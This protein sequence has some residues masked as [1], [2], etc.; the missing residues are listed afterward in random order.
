MADSAALTALILLDRDGV[1]N[2]DSPDYIRS[3]E[4]FVPLPGALDAMVRLHRAGFR[5]GICTNQSAIGRGYVGEAGV[6]EIHRHLERELERLGGALAGIAYCPHV[7]DAG[8][9]CRKPRPGMLLSLMRAAGIGACATT[10][11]GD[12][13]RDLEAAQAARCRGVL[14]RTG[15]GSIAEADAKAAG[16]TEVYADLA[17]FASAE[18]ARIRS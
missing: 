1:I 3:V 11:V 14:V 17:E 15:K 4:E 7:P 2:E 16:F 12:S 18:I 5:L 10:F 13:M 6:I 8:C 9:D